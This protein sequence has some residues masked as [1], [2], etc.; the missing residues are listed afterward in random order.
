[1]KIMDTG[2][3]GKTVVI[4]GGAAGIGLATVRMFLNE[5]AQVVAGD[6]DIAELK[7]VDSDR[8]LPV[9]VDLGIPSGADDLVSAAAKNFGG[10]DCL[11]NNVGI[12]PTRENFIDVSDSDW[13]RVID[14]NFYSMVRACRAA[15]PYMEQQGSGSIVSVA[16]EV[17]RQ[18]DPF[19]VDYSVSK[20]AVVC[21]AKALSTEYGPA[22]IRSNCVTPGPTRTSI[23]DRPG[24][25]ADYLADQYG[26][27]KEAAT[28]HFAKEVR[29]LPLGRI[30]QPED[31]AA[32]IVFLSS[33]RARQVTG[34]D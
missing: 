18:P 1:V 28:E 19:L 27:E 16:S 21:L 20:A 23:W 25:F 8:L 13:Q 14:V 2:L 3:T 22:G 6:L 34:A 11:V 30:G 4:T 5:G 29:K 17:A 7:S 12:A 10:V 33:D 32:A 24:G 26:L 15:I 9:E 31:V